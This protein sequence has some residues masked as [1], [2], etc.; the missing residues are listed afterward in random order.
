MIEGGQHFGFTCEAGDTLRIRRER[1]GQDFQRD[2]ALEASVA[3]FVDLSHA[4]HAKHR[5]DVIRADL[6]T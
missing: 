5:H 2:V 4:A 1:F 6:R 3:S